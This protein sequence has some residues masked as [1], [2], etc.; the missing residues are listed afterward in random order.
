MVESAH[1]TLELLIAHEV[2][3]NRLYLASA[4]VFAD[5]SDFWQTLA[6]EEKGH[7][8]KLAGLRSSPGLDLWLGQERSLVKP[9]AVR[10]SIEYVDSQAARVREGGLSLR[11]ALA[12]AKDLE[13]ALIE[14]MSLLACCSSDADIVAV[15][16]EL[17]GETERHRQVITDA[18][19]TE[20]RLNP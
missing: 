5:L 17:K 6:A 1:E 14:R 20:K 16:F 3:I 12:V 18:L 7:V 13:D 8:T 10:S 11:Q 9:Q 2:A 15:L 19:D 4:A